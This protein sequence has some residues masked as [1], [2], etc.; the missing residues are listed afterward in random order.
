MFIAILSTNAYVLNA[1]KISLQ[2]VLLLKNR[3]I[4]LRNTLVTL[5]LY[6]GEQS[7]TQYLSLNYSQSQ[8]I[9]TTISGSD[10]NLVTPSLFSRTIAYAY[11]TAAT[12]CL[13]CIKFILLRGSV[14]RVH[15]PHTGGKEAKLKKSVI[16]YSRS[17][18]PVSMCA[19]GTQTVAYTF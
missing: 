9:K 3:A 10:L 14:V 16:L 17:R 18:L 15:L 7:W 12:S 13:P 1:V 8:L 11:I 4:V 19:R 5:S 2:L 6:S